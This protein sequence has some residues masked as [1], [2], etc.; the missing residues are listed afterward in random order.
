VRANGSAA[1]RESASETTTL[2]PRAEGTVPELPARLLPATNGSAT[3]KS[4]PPRQEQAPSSETARETPPAAQARKKPDTK[5]EL[6]AA[7]ARQTAPI[8]LREEQARDPEPA[9]E[10]A[11]PTQVKKKAKTKVELSAASPTPPPPTRP[12]L[13]AR[14]DGHPGPKKKDERPAQPNAP[15][16]I[17]CRNC[18][19]QTAPTFL[20]EGRVRCGHCQSVF[21]FWA[22]APPPAKKKAETAQAPYLWRKPIPILAGTVLALLL[23]F[24]FRSNLFGKS[25]R[26]RVYPAQGKAT[27]AGKPIPEA[28]IFLHP[29]GPR[30]LHIPRPRAVVGPDGTF[31]LGTYRK[32]DGAPPGDYQVTVQWFHKARGHTLPA[33]VLPP[34]YASP[35]TSGLTVR[36]GKGENQLPPLQLTR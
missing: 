18:G 15:G 35:G 28:T 33:N 9:R 5:L 3:G 19:R 25:D 24:L 34:R 29:I 26:V 23:V 30:P 14:E 13:P 27:F 6:T 16:M 17:T 8:P 21:P 12:R 22:S 31:V 10:A 36:I 11:P 1:P 7:S 32:D 4:S 20:C 2:A